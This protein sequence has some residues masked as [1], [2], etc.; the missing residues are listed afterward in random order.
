VEIL[1]VPPLGSEPPGEQPILTF[2]NRQYD[3]NTLSDEIKELV[4]GL[5]VADGQIQFQEDTLRVLAIGRQAMALQLNDRLQSVN[6][7]GYIQPQG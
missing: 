5:Q 6:P 1:D 7:V 4:R 2:E 3:F